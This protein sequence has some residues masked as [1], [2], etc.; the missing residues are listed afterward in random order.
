MKAYEDTTENLRKNFVE[1][2]EALE[3][4]NLKLK[5]DLEKHLSEKFLVDNK[6]TKLTGDLQ[7]YLDKKNV[8]EQ[9]N[10]RFKFSV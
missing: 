10:V 9:E 1:R 3:K 4:E 8:V 6:N 2:I 5:E 7:R